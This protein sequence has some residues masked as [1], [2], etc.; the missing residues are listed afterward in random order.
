MAQVRSSEDLRVRLQQSSGEE[1]L[2]FGWLANTSAPNVTD[3]ETLA[4]DIGIDI[5]GVY[6]GVENEIDEPRLPPKLFD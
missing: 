6:V 2:A 1:I 5:C 4:L 3:S